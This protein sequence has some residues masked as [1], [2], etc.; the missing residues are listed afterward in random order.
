MAVKALS[1]RQREEYSAENVG[2]RVFVDRAETLLPPLRA[3]ANI[4]R[5]QAAL[6]T[7]GWQQVT[8]LV[9]TESVRLGVGKPHLLSSDTTVQEPQSG[10]PHAAGILRGSAQRVYRAAVKLQKRGSLHA[11]FAIEKAKEVLGRVKAYYTSHGHELH[12]FKELK[13]ESE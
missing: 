10:Y 1:A 5:A 3:H 8:H 9:V 4:A 2:A 12:F 13:T 6:G 11:H 7:A